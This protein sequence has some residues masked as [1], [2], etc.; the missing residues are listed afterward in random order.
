MNIK[1]ILRVSFVAPVC[2]Y[3]VMAN[4]EAVG[5]F[6]GVEEV[7]FSTSVPNEVLHWVRAETLRKL[8]DTPEHKASVQYIEDLLQQH[9]RDNTRSDVNSDNYKIQKELDDYAKEHKQWNLDSFTGANWNYILLCQIIMDVQKYKFVG[10]DAM[11]TTAIKNLT[12]RNT[13]YAK[14]KEALELASLDLRVY[15]SAGYHAVMDMAFYIQNCGVLM[16]SKVDKFYIDDNRLD[17][18]IEAKSN[19]KENNKNDESYQDIR[20][21]ILR[22]LTQKLAEEYPWEKVWAK[23]TGED[24][25]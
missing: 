2:V 25:K 21:R 24:F 23:L 12:T 16:M 9:L 7:I 13:E 17:P 15:L 6:K 14:Y 10:F 18:Q 11:F 20:K 5:E 1:G 4:Q 3:C 22:Q 8:P 19:C